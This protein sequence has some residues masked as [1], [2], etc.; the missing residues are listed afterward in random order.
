MKDLFQMG[1]TRVGWALLIGLAVAGVVA[2]VISGLMPFGRSGTDR[3]EATGSV[4]LSKGCFRQT[5]NAGWGGGNCKGYQEGDWVP[6]RLEIANGTDVNLTVNSSNALTLSIDYYDSNNNAIGF[7]SIR[8]VVYGSCEQTPSADYNNWTPAGTALAFQPV[9]WTPPGTGL[10]NPPALQTF[11]FPTS[12]S[13]TVPS[14]QT[15]CV[16]WQAHLSITNFWNAQTPSH[17]GSSFWN[18]ASLHVH[19]DMPN[20]G[21]QD[22]PIEVPPRPAGTVNAHKFEDVDGDG[23]QDPGEPNIQY[24]PIHVNYEDPNFPL[25]TFDLYACTNASGD[26]SFTTMPPGA[27]VTSEGDDRA[28]DFGGDMPTPCQP[29]DSTTW[30]H[31]TAASDSFTLPAGGTHTSVFGNQREAPTPTPTPTSTNTPTPTSTFTP[32]PTNTFTPTPT[33]TST[34][35]PTNTFTPTPTNTSTATPTNTFTPTPT[36]T[37]TATPT[38]T[39]TATPTDTPTA[40]PTDTPTATPT[41]TFTPLATDTPT[42][43]ATATHPPTAT[44]E[45]HHT[46]TP[47]KTRTPVPTATAAPAIVA[48]TP[49]PV[50]E[51]LEVVK[52]PPTGSGGGASSGPTILAVLLSTGGIVLLLSGLRLARRRTE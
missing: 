42:A 28:D 40:T 13:F 29:T 1:R 41:G 9:G 31:T 23:T 50:T 2:L 46:A 32:T 52:M 27:Y 18:G 39:P 38:D 12:G 19:I 4:S 11:T 26:V 44:E 10:T 37:P 20:E 43:T 5:P 30:V 8:N 47:T 33:N 16:Y 51:V 22:V 14:G 15:M 45:R 36:D 21:S 48:P 6:E 24:W 34:A 35:T 25:F 17:N 49:T 3:A 7:D